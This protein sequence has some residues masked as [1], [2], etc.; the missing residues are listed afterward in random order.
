M[1]ERIRKM[2][3]EPGL[4]TVTQQNM[5][6]LMPKNL[7]TSP[8]CKTDLQWKYV[9]NLFFGHKVLDELRILTRLSSEAARPD[10]AA[11]ERRAICTN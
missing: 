8:T 1:G 3:L 11:R 7:K 10:Q 4:P 6:K 9:R 2:E 5:E